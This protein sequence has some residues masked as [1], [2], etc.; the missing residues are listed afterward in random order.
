LSGGTLA[1]EAMSEEIPFERV[2]T[3][4][5]Y[6]DGP[7]KGIA[8]FRGTPH[9]YESKWSDIEDDFEDSFLLTPV[10]EDVFDAALEHWAIWLRW[11]EAFHRGIALQESHP[12][13]PA[14]R[15]RHDELEK[16]LGGQLVT[17]PACAIEAYGE[18]RPAAESSKHF[19]WRELEVR[20]RISRNG[21]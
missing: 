16:L 4:T 17:N 5:D 11:E 20:W 19:G 18:F 7:R 13:L 6:Y 21:G 8:N 1:A 10:N 9:L 12:A 15:P 3:M 14:D 2:F